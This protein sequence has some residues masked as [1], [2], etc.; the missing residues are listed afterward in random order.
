MVIYFVLFIIESILESDLKEIVAPPTIEITRNI[1]AIV[2]N[3]SVKLSSALLI[4]TT[5]K[6]VIIW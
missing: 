6:A 4:S 2:M 3:K 1:G 5:G